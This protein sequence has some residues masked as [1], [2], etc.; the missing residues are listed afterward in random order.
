M[1][2]AGIRGGTVRS[3]AEAP[4]RGPATANKFGGSARGDSLSSRQ[5]GARQ[6]VGQQGGTLRS[7]STG[8]G[9]GDR[10]AAG[11]R[12][13]GGGV[14]AAARVRAVA[15]AVV[16][17]AAAR[18]RAVAPTVV[19]LAAARVRA[20]AQAVVELAAAP[21]QAAAIC[22]AAPGTDPAGSAEGLEASAEATRAPTAAAAPRAWA[23]DQAV[24]AVPGAAADGGGSAGDSEMMNRST[25]MKASHLPIRPNLAWSVA[26]SMFGYFLVSRSSATLLPSRKRRRTKRPSTRPKPGPSLQPR[27]RRM[28]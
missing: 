14:G 19:E 3:I 24:A 12:T 4:P 2:A 17:L 25:N 9:V 11:S 7:N 16:E 15:P 27:K 23:R 20:V 21:L 13:G 1:L 10:S 18:V 5:S 6:Q 8:A 28:L 22:P 26:L